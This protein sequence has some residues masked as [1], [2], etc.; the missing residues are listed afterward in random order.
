M[1]PGRHVRRKGAATRTPI[2]VRRRHLCRSRRAADNRR[3]SDPALTWLYRCQEA[4]AARPAVRMAPE[5]IARAYV[6]GPT[7]LRLAV[8]MLEYARRVGDQEVID[9]ALIWTTG[10][11]A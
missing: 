2:S 5:P 7:A 9:R 11:I 6:D 10:M 1:N 8:A 3:S 4:L